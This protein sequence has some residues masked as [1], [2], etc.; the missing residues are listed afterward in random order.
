MVYDSLLLMAILFVATGVAVALNQGQAVSHPLYYLSLLA[1]TYVFFCW[2]W[3]HGGQTLGMR[4]WRLQLETE[5]GTDMT[6]SHAGKRFV[7][8]TISLLPFGAGLIWQ[9]LDSDRLALHDRLSASR[10][11]F[12]PKGMPGSQ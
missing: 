4:T 11:V 5:S 9:L 7:Y 1:I 3:T 6:W 10:I 12:L 2:F 8:A